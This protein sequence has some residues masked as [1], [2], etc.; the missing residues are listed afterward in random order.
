M[1]GLESIGESIWLIEG[2]I[3]S[4]YGFPYPTRCVIIRLK[5]NL[6]WVWSPVGLTVNLRT[7]V[8]ELGRVGHLVSPNKIHHLFLQDWKAAYP[9]A[10]IWGPAS[11]IRK[12]KDLDFQRPLTNEAPIEWANEIDQ[13]WFTGSPALDEVVFYH[14]ASRTAILADLSENFSNPFLNKHWAAWQRSIA[15]IWKIVEPFGYPPLELRLS[16]WRRE[17]ARRT[18]SRLL[19]T[20]PEKVVMAHGEWQRSYGRSY[21]EKVFEWLG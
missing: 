21:L 13:F 15:R 17:D 9:S 3:V 8:D 11:T 7:Q 18:L 6:L 14:R 12:R 16:W 10:R 5:N 20:N 1:T 4:F 2:E 19:A